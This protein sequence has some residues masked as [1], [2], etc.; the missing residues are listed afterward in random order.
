MQRNTPTTS[1]LSDVI[2]KMFACKQYN[3]KTNSLHGLDWIIIEL[4]NLSRQH[5]NNKSGVGIRTQSNYVI[6]NV[7]FDQQNIA[8]V[9]VTDSALYFVL[10]NWPQS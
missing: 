7:I 9:I 2:G 8:F 10:H 4:L 5:D 6:V 1:T 3:Y